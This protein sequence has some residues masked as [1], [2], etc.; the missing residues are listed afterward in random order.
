[1]QRVSCNKLRNREQKRKGWGLEL[2]VPIES[3]LNPSCSWQL[4]DEDAETASLHLSRDAGA[5]NSPAAAVE[6]EEEEEEEGKKEEEEE[7]EG[8]DNF[9]FYNGILN[10]ET[11]H[12]LMPYSSWCCLGLPQKIDTKMAFI[13]LSSYVILIFTVK[14]TWKIQFAGSYSYQL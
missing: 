3:G 14:G 12:G 11:G 4:S 9:F 6:K 13:L 8:D 7:E 5:C 1:M 10:T 2:E